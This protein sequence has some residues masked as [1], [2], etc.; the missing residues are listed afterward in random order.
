MQT[1]LPSIYKQQQRTVTITKKRKVDLGSDGFTHWEYIKHKIF[2]HQK[3]CGVKYEKR[4]DLSAVKKLETMARLTKII[5]RLNV[6]KPALVALMTHSN[7]F[8]ITLIFTVL[9]RI[10]DSL[11]SFD[12]M[13]TT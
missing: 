11:G 5:K 13:R 2:S 12:N 6:P 1:K 7:G 3:S 8:L 10:F 4:I 9:F